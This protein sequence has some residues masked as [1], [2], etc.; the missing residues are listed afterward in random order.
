MEKDSISMY[1]WYSKV[2]IRSWF[3]YRVDAILKSLAV[4]CREA[5]GITCVILLFLKFDALKIGGWGLW[6]L[7][8]L[9]SF[10]F[11]TYSL[12][13]TFFT[14]LRDFPEYIRNGQFDRFL[15]R[16]RGILFQVLASNTDWF[17]MI[18]HGTLGV[19]LLVAAS[20]HLNIKWNLASVLYYIITIL[21]GTLIQAAVWMFIAACSFRFVKTTNLSRIIFYSLRQIAGYPI[22]FFPK[23]I[24]ILM[25]WVVPFAFVNYF[26]AQYFLHIE[27]DI[28]Y[29][30][31]AM[32]LTPVVGVVM[33][34][35]TYAFWRYSLRIYKSTGN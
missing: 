29:E 31:V 19:A 22:V 27:S 35:L 30:A 33:Y 2:T 26:P 17:A 13:V 14:G 23:T 8:F 4:L 6:Q 1:Y 32:Y 12:L 9:Y 21:G 7:V 28:S 5:C 15:L 20:I 25:T 18:G 10:I 3:Q 24:R 16:P 34:V 11:I